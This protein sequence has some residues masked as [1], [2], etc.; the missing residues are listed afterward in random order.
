M[1]GG[2]LAAVTLLPL[3]AA[4]ALLAIP[5]E[6]EGLHRGIGFAGESSGASA[7]ERATFLQTF[8]RWIASDGDWRIAT[9]S[10]APRGLRPSA[11]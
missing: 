7:P 5:R 8:L 6:E 1:T 2:L 10:E 3:A 4:L 11:Q 9:A